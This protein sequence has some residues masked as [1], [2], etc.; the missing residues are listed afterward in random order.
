MWGGGGGV[1]S[2]LTGKREAFL[3]LKDN[4]V[5]WHQVIAHPSIEDE[6]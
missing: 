3:K 2:R 1:S 5:E 6:Y 4:I